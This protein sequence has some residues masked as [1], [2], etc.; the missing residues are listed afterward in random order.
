MVSVFLDYRLINR[1]LM[2]KNI[3]IIG[4]GHWGKNLIR[5]F[6]SLGSLN[7]VS[8]SDSETAKSF[9][10]Q[11]DIPSISFEEMIDSIDIE[12]VVIAAPAVLHSNLAIKALNAGK[13]V[14]VEKPLATNIKDAQSMIDCAKKSGKHLMVGHLLQYH[15][16]FIKL[17]KLVLEG[18][19]G[20]LEYIYSNR[21]SLG[22]I[23]VDEN[24]IW[25][26]APHDISMIISL[27]NK[28]PS[29]VLAVGNQQLGR[30]IED[31]AIIHLDFDTEIQAHIEVSWINPYKQ[32][33]LVVVGSKSML[34]FDDSKPW[35]EKLMFFDHSINLDSTPPEIIKSEGIE[36]KVVETEPLMNECLHFI[37][38]VNNNYKP[39]TD[40]EEGMRV[41]EVLHA[42][43]SSLKSGEFENV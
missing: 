13:H 25:S 43:D 12:G 23:R 24:I 15:P 40:A 41:L 32:H 35:N 20:N 26:F 22:K 1:L 36:I 34:V 5:N 39:I 6:H 7:S 38:V 42:T 21:L 9:S 18:K 3:G 37:E 2:R 28:K 4:C 31:R 33:K 27:V 14:F 10:K 29:K 11:Y 19:I 17:K 16:V 30:K 8:D